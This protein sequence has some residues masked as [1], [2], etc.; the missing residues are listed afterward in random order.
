MPTRPPGTNCTVR[1]EPRR[2]PASAIATTTC[3]Q[4]PKTRAR[5]ASARTC[6]HRRA[7]AT[8]SAAMIASVAERHPDLAFDFALAHRDRVDRLVDRSTSAPS[9]RSW[10]PT[11]SMRRCPPSSR[12]SPTRSAPPTRAGAPMRRSQGSAIGSMCAQRGWRRSTR[13]STRGRDERRCS[14]RPGRAGS[15]LRSL[16]PVRRADD[17]LDRPPLPLLP[18]PAHPPHAALHRDGDDRRAAAWRRRR[19]ISI[20]TTRSIPVALQLGGSEPAELAACAKLARA[21]GLRRDQPQLRLPERARAA[22]RV[23]RLPDGRAALVADCVTAMR[24]A[25]RSR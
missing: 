3:L 7:R 22:R 10:P 17:G 2:R 13:G 1:R 18:S 19:A 23:R 24:D 20:S 14:R 16:A 6:A 9:T 8:N 15:T 12:P 25:S 5:P 21:L 11:R 4:A